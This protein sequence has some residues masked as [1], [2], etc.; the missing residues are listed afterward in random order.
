VSNVEGVLDRI[1]QIV[2]G[3]LLWGEE[4]ER[5]NA[6]RLLERIAEAKDS[7]LSFVLIVEDPSGNSAI[8]SDKAEKCTFATDT[9]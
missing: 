7:S 1:E 5:V 9:R 4:E 8:V 2:K 6:M 3:A